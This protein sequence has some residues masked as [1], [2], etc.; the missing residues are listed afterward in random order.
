[1]TSSDD[2]FAE[3]DVRPILREGGEPFADIM[4]AVANLKPGQGLR[5]FATFKP[6]P[7]FSV[8]GAQGFT[9]EEREIGD[10]DWEILFRPGKEA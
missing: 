9:H 3:L 2:D 1:M 10:G 6:V 8:L 7:L 5:L 4:G